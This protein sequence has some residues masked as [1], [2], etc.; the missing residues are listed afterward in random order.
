MI[1][2]E[3]I[4]K[5]IDNV[6][7]SKETYKHEIKKYKIEVLKGNKNIIQLICSSIHKILKPIEIQA[8]VKLSSAKL[9]K[10]FMELNNKEFIST[11]KKNILPLMLNVARFKKDEISDLKSK[12]FSYFFSNFVFPCEHFEVL[13][14]SFFTLIIECIIAWQV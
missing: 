7:V 2:E 4:N 5:F 14:N 3:E 11:V 10:E 1:K 12:G 8:F 6:L 9:L 13:S